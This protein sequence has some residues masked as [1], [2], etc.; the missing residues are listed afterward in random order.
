MWKYNRILITN[1]I[2][3]IWCKLMAYVKMHSYMKAY[4]SYKVNKTTIYYA[5]INVLDLSCVGRSVGK[6]II[7]PITVKPRR[8]KEITFAS[9]CA[10]IVWS[11][12][13]SCSPT[14]NVLPPNVGCRYMV[15]AFSNKSRDFGA[16][17]GVF[18]GVCD[19]ACRLLD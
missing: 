12:R 18:F 6:T 14:S 4:I 10:I 8:R 15:V 9:T 11:S 16:N 2:Y 17:P 19:T 3:S 7:M 13:V 1:M 5:Y